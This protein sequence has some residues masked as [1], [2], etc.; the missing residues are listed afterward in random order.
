METIQKVPDGRSI[1]PEIKQKVLD[2]IKDGTV[3]VS[4]AAKTNNI[5]PK[6]IYGWLARD[7]S[8]IQTNSTEIIRLR[9]ENR[10]LLELI[11]KLTHGLERS[12]KKNWRKTL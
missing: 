7:A 1:D 3:G 4:E 8:P 10:A 5:S 6:T 12:K 9:R 2:L 11:G